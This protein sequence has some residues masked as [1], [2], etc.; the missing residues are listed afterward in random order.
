MSFFTK[1]PKTE[2]K[3]DILYC[4]PD[5]PIKCQKKKGSKYEPFAESWVH[6]DQKDDVIDEKIK[7]RTKIVEDIISK[8]EAKVKQKTPEWLGLRNDKESASDCGA[9]VGLDDH[10]LQYEFLFSKL[11]R[12]RFDA[13]KWCY[14][15]NKYEEIANMLYSYRKNVQVLEIGFVNHKTCKFIGIS[16]DGIISKY[17]LDGKTLTKYAGRM[18][19]IK[20]PPKRKILLEGKIKGEIVPIHYWAQV[21]MQLECCDLDDCDFWQCAIE[22]YGSRD[23]FIKDTNKEEPFRSAETDLEKGCL[24]QLLPITKIT[25]QG[26]DYDQA[27]YESSKFIH[28]PKIEMSPLDC[29]VWIAKVMSSIYKYCG[30][31]YYFDK[32]I[33]WKLVRSKCVTIERDKQWFKEKFPLLEKM[34]N[35]VEFFRNN[36]DKKL[37]L[38]D[39]ADHLEVKDNDKIMEIAELLYNVPK[40]QTKDKMKEYNNRVKKLIDDIKKMK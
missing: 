25:C 29:D 4:Y 13:N 3:P 22:E 36:E 27:V 39:Y 34:W 17:K 6:D 37:I 19:E 40:T 2:S 14:H 31:E 11:G 20:C 12:S 35:Y 7:K 30:S 28:P 5:F 26:E 16:P 21:Q 24:I 9:I 32:I 8:P 18:L 1:K 33:Y 15:G 23:E 10:K 38:F